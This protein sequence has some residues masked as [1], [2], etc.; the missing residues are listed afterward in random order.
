MRAGRA[1]RT[2]EHNALF[3]MLETSLPPRA[4]LFDDR[5]ASAFLTGPLAALRVVVRVPGGARTI[6]ALIDHRWPGARTSVAART[7]LIDDTIDVLP[8]DRFCQLVVLGA[9]FDTRAYRL[10]RLRSVPVFEVDHPDTQ[11]VKRAVLQRELPAIPDNVTFVPS[12]FNLGALAETMAASGYQ[13]S[14]P[15][16]FLWEGVT[17]YLTEQAVDGML[18]W[19]AAAVPDSILLFTYVHSDVLSR[20]EGFVGGRR[21]HATLDK[22]GEQFTFGMDPTDMK[23]YLHERGLDLEWDLGASEYRAR[24]FGTRARSMVG[25]EFYRVAFARVVRHPE[26]ERLPSSAAGLEQHDGND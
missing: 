11:A 17:N 21:L 19:C 24:Y 3:R 6:C 12:D 18:R 14:L 20:P 5:L 7:K 2:A 22:V 13:P 1:S 8:A 4:R 15:T 25:H 9:G 23:G 16:L 26:P 10:R